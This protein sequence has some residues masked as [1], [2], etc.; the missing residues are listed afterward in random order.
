MYI[1]RYM[2]RNKYIHIY[3]YIYIY[4]KTI[5]NPA[6]QLDVAE[7]GAALDHRVGRKDSGVDVVDAERVSAAPP[8]A[9]HPPL[10]GRRES[11]LL[12]QRTSRSTGAGGGG[13][14]RRRQDDMLYIYI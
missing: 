12:G 2:Y 6:R 4:I 13:G 14:S 11:H 5:I 8:A 7:G 10:E 1:Y 9:P 3:T